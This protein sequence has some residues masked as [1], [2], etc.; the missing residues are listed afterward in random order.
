MKTEQVYLVIWTTLEF[1]VR[2]D[3]R[4][5]DIRADKQAR[6][7]SDSFQILV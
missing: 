6:K 3:N 2:M 1:Y 4:T 7:W 5:L